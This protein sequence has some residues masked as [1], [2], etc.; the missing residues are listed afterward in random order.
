[1]YDGANDTEGDYV[2]ADDETL[3]AYNEL[4]DTLSA[5]QVEY[6]LV[7]SL[8]DEGVELPSDVQ[9]AVTNYLQPVLNIYEG[10]Y[11]QR[12][13]IFSLLED[14]SF[15]DSEDN[16]RFAEIREINLRQLNGYMLSEN[17][18]VYDNNYAALYGDL[19]DILKGNA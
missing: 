14:L 18:G 13:L 11:M 9:T 7:G 6:Y 8:S 5:S 12:E 3:N 19:I 1:M 17:G 4:T 2:L 15:T 10:T 16:L